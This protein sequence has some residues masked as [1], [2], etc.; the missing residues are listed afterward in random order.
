MKEI[1][2]LL[3]KSKLIKIQESM[4]TQILLKETNLQYFDSRNVTQGHLKVI[5]GHFRSFPVEHFLL[6]KK[7]LGESRHPMGT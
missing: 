7:M 1:A 4:S 5:L 3:I 6:P 2:Y